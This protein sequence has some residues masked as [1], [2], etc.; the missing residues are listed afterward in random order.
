MRPPQATCLPCLTTSPITSASLL[1][2][3]ISKI[4]L[5]D[6]PPLV[7]GSCCVGVLRAGLPATT[8]VTASHKT[9]E[10]LMRQVGLS[11][12]QVC[13]G[14]NAASTWREEGGFPA[15]SPSSVAHTVVGGAA[16]VL[17]GWDS[18]HKVKMVDQYIMCFLECASSHG[19]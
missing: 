14:Q 18:E 3:S 6:I 1:E 2:T 5:S 19:V 4:L 15:L 16:F 10:T 9:R 7:P 11:L 8:D 13:S 17:G 12:M